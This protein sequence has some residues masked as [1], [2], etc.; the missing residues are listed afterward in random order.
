ML[1]KRTPQ[2][3][4]VLARITQPPPSPVA[5]KILEVVR[6]ERAGARNLAEVINKDQAFT[7]RILKLVNSAYYGLMQKV[8]TVSRAVSVLGFDTIRS[9]A[10]TLYTFGHF[11][12]EKS[13]FIT[14]GQLWEHSLGCAIGARR[15]ASQAGHNSP[16]E[17]F[18][19]GLLHD[20]GKTL[21]YQYFKKEFI[22]A[23]KMAKEE[24]IG[25]FEAEI[26]IL[27]TDHAT[28]G[29]VWARKWNLPP[30]IQHTIRFHRQ[31]LLVPEDVDFSVRQV[32][33]MV[34][35]ADLFCEAT[36]I[37]SGG[38]SSV[39][40][41]VEE[42]VWSL[43][44]MGE[45][46]CSEVLE[47]VAEEV[48]MTK[49][50]LGIGIVKETPSDPQGRR[51]FAFRTVRKS[52]S[53]SNGQNPDGFQPPEELLTKFS[54]VMEAGKQVAVLAG[55]EELLPNIAFHVKTLAE[56]DAAGILVPNDDSLEIV[57]A[58]GLDDL[59]GRTIPAEGSL[60]G[61]VS[62]MGEPV[63]IANID[64]ASPSWEKEFFGG[65]GYLSLLLLP[66]EWA[67]ERIAV[68]SIHDRR[69]RLWKPEEISLFNTFVGFVAVALENARLYRETEERSAALKALNQNLEEAL[70]LKKKFLAVITHELRTPMNVILGYT[71]L[72][73]E[74]AFGD[75]GAKIRDAVDKVLKGAEHLLRLIDA[76]L[77]ISRIDSGRAEI[78]C[79]PVDVRALLE[80]VAA[81][82][83][84][85]LEGKPIVLSRDY[86]RQLPVV[87]T[88]RER[89]KQVLGH[90]LDN[91]VRFTPEGRIFLRAIAQREGVEI[92]VE[93]T[94][95]GIEAKDKK[96]IFEGFRQVED[97]N[98][99]KYG[100]LGVGLYAVQRLL[101]MLGGTISLE[102]QVDR[103]STFRVWLP[104]GHHRQMEGALQESAV[105]PDPTSSQPHLLP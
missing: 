95:I 62:K 84:G 94:G 86:D 1:K 38:D 36:N 22:E 50:I 77:D 7:A 98:I 60:A 67:G 40:P 66:V 103:G 99:R 79:A 44:A 82:T 13:G 39:E 45:T 85:L 92:S 76:I 6:D 59:L 71:R 21:F 105:S 100:G 16:E 58:V 43:L 42:G 55:L 2:V 17:A 27:G 8:T 96:I 90:I 37:G 14:M 101:E 69:E 31:P 26:C 5:T 89:L 81:S 28:A 64:G 4:R 19:A 54:D 10:L 75:P 46:E 72:I 97:P 15:I 63:A 49:E 70:S 57:G 73:L 93:D 104:C 102:S 65:V 11:A 47:A 23:V 18:V 29:E 91:A 51:P 87:F 68:L 35:L 74:E 20:M 33:A 56:A 83:A 32:V 61:W 3:D 9:L 80:E 53:A 48:E 25:L 30:V 34:H 24:G 12:N 41:V 52:Q 78:H 88:D